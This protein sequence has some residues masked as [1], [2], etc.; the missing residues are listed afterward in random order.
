[1]TGEGICTSHAAGIQS[2][3]EI[4][5]AI[6]RAIACR[7]PMAAVYEGRE[8]L[9]CP[10]MLGRNKEGCRRL[11]GYQYGGESVSGLQRKDGRGDWRCFDIGKISAIRLLPDAAWQTAD[12]HSRRPGCIARIEVQADDQPEGTPQ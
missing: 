11:L 8:R 1:M 10:Y 6:R 7:H 2:Q 12:T 5:S 4:D 3:D 9:L